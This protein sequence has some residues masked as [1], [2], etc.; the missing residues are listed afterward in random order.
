MSGLCTLLAGG[1]GA[2][3]AT[4]RESSRA[5]K[6]GFPMTSPEKPITPVGMKNILVAI[7]FSE[8]SQ[9]ALAHAAALA[10]IFG[11]TV[12]GAHVVPFDKNPFAE[13]ESAELALRQAGLSAK[14]QIGKMFSQAGISAGDSQILVGDG[15]VGGVIAGLVREHSADLLVVGTTGRQGLEKVLLGSVAEELI[16]S[17]PCPVLSIGPDVADKAPATIASIVCGIDFSPESLHAAP[18]AFRLARMFA[19]QVTV[20]HVAREPEES[21]VE[22]QQL[23]TKRLKEQVWPDAGPA[24]PDFVVAFGEPAAELLKVASERNAGLIVIGVRG[25]GAFTRRSTHFGS[26]AHEVVSQAPCPVLT[27]REW[28]DEEDH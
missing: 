13:P 23:L 6:R 10:R 2:K 7:D 3:C 8:I 18:Y 22:M 17:S 9:R 4:I 16:R 21:A 27:V 26:T 12:Y 5:E 24:G 15:D 14:E 28:E 19:A 1:A 20:V 25:S 11:A